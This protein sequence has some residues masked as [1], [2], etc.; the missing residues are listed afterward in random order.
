MSPNDFAQR[1]HSDL[2]HFIARAQG[3]FN[4]LA[5]GSDVSRNATALRMGHD[6]RTFDSMRQVPSM[7]LLVDLARACG[8]S[9]SAVF[10]VASS[11]SRAARV[12]LASDV[13]SDIATD[14]ARDERLAAIARAD[15]LDDPHALM[16]LSEET[17]RFSGAHTDFAM[18]CLLHARALSASG[19]VNE[20]ARLADVA[21]QIGFAPS[22]LTLANTL[23]RCVRGEHMLGSPWQRGSC[24]RARDHAT[25]ALAARDVADHVADHVEQDVALH[26]TTSPISASSNAISARERC[27]ALATSLCTVHPPTSDICALAVAA[28]ICS[29]QVEV[30][31]AIS[32]LE[33]ATTDDSRSCAR[34]R[35]A[36]CCSIAA[37]SALRLLDK[38]LEPKTKAQV[39]RVLVTTQ[40]ALSDQVT[41]NDH[42]ENLMIQRRRARVILCEWETRCATGELEGALIDE[43]EATEFCASVVCFPSALESV[44]VTHV[45][46]LVHWGDFW[47][48]S[49]FA[50]D[51]LSSDG[52]MCQFQGLH[53]E[54]GHG[55][56]LDRRI[57]VD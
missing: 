14:S 12:S 49:K 39:L 22:E 53:V 52:W 20:A 24:A 47:R 3:V 57:Y 17:A 34:A 11:G 42:A 51:A 30:N 15:V 46:E 38:P 48:N 4:L 33:S 26:T 25:V 13:A 19:K 9:T 23:E 56:D 54:G 50:L 18:S 45:L 1:L 28:K 8:W 43:A 36:W 40:F 16:Q 41:F 21:R 6:L 10:R 44:V 29:L 2:A 55:N 35:L 27:H 37:I 5:C 32:A 7:T 31:D